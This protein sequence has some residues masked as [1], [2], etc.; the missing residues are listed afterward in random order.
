MQAIAASAGGKIVKPLV[1]IIRTEEPVE[2]ALRFVPPMIVARRVERL[3]ARADRRG[4]LDRLLVVFR[5]FSAA[6]PEAVR[7]DRTEAAVSPALVFHE[8]AEGRQPGVTHPV[9]A[10]P[11]SGEDECMAEP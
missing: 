1:E 3:D 4:G 11:T 5:R 9:V 10:G 6:V 2:G 8:P 7:A